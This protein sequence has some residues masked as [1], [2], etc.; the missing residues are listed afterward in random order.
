M[1]NKIREAK[2]FDELLDIKYGKIGAEKRN[3]HRAFH[4]K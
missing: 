3:R 1:E 2:N 4:S